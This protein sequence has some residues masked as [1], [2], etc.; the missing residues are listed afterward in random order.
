MKDLHYIELKE[1]H[2]IINNI[3]DGSIYQLDKNNNLIKRYTGFAIKQ[4]DNC[5]KLDIIYLT[6]TTLSEKEYTYEFQTIDEIIDI[7]YSK[8]GYSFTNKQTLRNI[9]NLIIGDLKEKK[10][11]GS[12]CLFRETLKKEENKSFIDKIKNKLK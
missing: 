2:W 7:L 9:I 1:N 6:I 11:T 4:I 5:P 3:K 10:Q 12:D 8:A